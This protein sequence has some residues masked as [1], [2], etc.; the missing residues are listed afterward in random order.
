MFSVSSV[1]ALPHL[2]FSSF[3]LSQFCYSI[4]SPLFCYRSV[5]LQHYLT[6]VLLSIS[7]VT[8]LAHLCFAVK[9]FC[10]SII[11]P[12]FCGQSVSSQHYLTS[13]LLSVSSVTALPHLCFVVSHFCSHVIHVCRA[14]STS[15]QLIRLTLAGRNAT[16][17]GSV[18]KRLNDIHAY[19][20][21]SSGM[22]MSDCF[23]LPAC[24]SVC[25]SCRNEGTS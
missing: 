10:Y 12:L 14:S 17:I 7:S 5:L 15:S 9:H 24:H 19:N 4:T 3:F 6:S 20:K 13:V 11:L 1:T 2:F 22:G 25:V 16:S 21:S 23:V 18:P 8:T